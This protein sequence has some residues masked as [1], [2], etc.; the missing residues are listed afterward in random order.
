MKNVILKCRIV[1]SI[2]YLF[3]SRFYDAYYVHYTVLST[4]IQTK[5]FTKSRFDD[6]DMYKKHIQYYFNVLLVFVASIDPIKHSLNFT[7]PCSS[8]LIHFI[9]SANDVFVLF[10][11]RHI[12]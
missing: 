6:E 5:R 1:D 9:H 12:Y 7:N 8:Y 11:N 2:I 10:P 4:Q 3:L